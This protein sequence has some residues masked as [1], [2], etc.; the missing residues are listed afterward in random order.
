MDHHSAAGAYRI[1]TRCVM[2]TS[3]PWITFDERGVCNHCNEFDRVLS[4]LWYRGGEGQ[5]RLDQLA[6]E[7]RR[8][9]KGKEYDCVIGVS[10]GVDSSYL[11]QLA[12]RR[13]GLRPLAVHVDAGWNSELA[14]ANIEN[15]VKKLGIDLFTYVV[16]WEEMRDLQVAYL[17]SGLANQDVPQDHAFAAKT[18]EFAV[19]HDIKY[20]L[21]GS[22]IA[23]ES[24]LPRAWGYDAMDSVQLRAIHR[25]FGTRPL[26]SY[27][28]LSAF[29][30]HF[31][32]PIL[33][34]LVYRQPL[35][36]ID[37]RKDEAK[38][39]L[40]SEFGWVYYGGKH[41]ESRWT[42]FFQSYYLPVRFGY[43]KRRA[44]LS[45]ILVAGEIDRATALKELEKPS[46]DADSIAQDV[47]YIEKKLRLQPG[48]IQQLMNMPRRE[49]NEYPTHRTRARVFLGMAV[50]VN[51]SMRV[52]RPSAVHA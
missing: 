46:Y 4:K 26:Q 9:G 21:N 16:D 20:V 51:K 7:I 1:C 10:G 34:G 44:H 5:R 17:K 47:E 19:K 29:R 23:T 28:I 8:N 12:V 41:Y 30:R 35:N 15:L 25:R 3:D 48:E 42:K 22:N 18:L 14:V 52:L 27:P 11:L 45:S 6:D 36:F 32:Y 37:Y 43:D 31:A 39:L 40:A 13:M 33:R 24:I 50:V 2:D 49:F 38:A